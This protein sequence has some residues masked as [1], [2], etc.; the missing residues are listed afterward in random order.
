VPDPHQHRR[1]LVLR[2][3]GQ[4]AERHRAQQLLLHLRQVRQQLID[5]L[6]HQAIGSGG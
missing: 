3:A 5:I 1:A 4:I 2:H 6:E